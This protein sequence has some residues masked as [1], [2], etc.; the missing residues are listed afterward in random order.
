MNPAQI[1]TI[2]F[3]IWIIRHPAFQK[4][5]N[6]LHGKENSPAK[7]KEGNASNF[8]SLKYFNF[9][10]PLIAIK[11]WFFPKSLYFIHKVLIFRFLQFFASFPF[12]DYL[13]NTLAVYL[14]YLAFYG[15]TASAFGESS[16]VKIFM[17][18]VCF[19]VNDVIQYHQVLSIRIF[20]FIVKTTRRLK[21]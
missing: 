19:F 12:P 6:F 11:S 7:M 14:Y 20:V 10:F 9:F 16:K 1:K 8:I 17:K 18:N 5:A 3:V 21:L 2:H 4:M 13:H 15:I